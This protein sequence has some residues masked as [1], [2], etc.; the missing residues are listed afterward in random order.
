MKGQK[1]HRG[2]I[3]SPS[4]CLICDVTTYGAYSQIVGDS[5]MKQNAIVIIII[6]II[7]IIN[8]PLESPLL[9]IGVSH[10]PP[11]ISISACMDPIICDALQVIGP[12]CRWPSSVS[13]IGARPPFQQPLC[14]PVVAHSRHVSCPIPL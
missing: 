11:P 12:T 13:L 6:I 5:E 2:D 1:P 4:I 14:P 9:D 10:G 7:I 8:Q 3:Y